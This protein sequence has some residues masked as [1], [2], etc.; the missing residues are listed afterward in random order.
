[1]GSETTAA[2]VGAVG[3]VRRD[4]MA[5]LPFCGYHMGDYFSHWFA[6]RKQIAEP[7]LIFGVNWFRKSAEG[8]FL[9]PGFGQNM[10]VL[11]WIVDRCHG[12]VPAKETSIGW[13]P[14]HGD[15][16]WRGM[17]DFGPAR[18]EEV[19]KVDPAEWRKELDSQQELF[20][21]LGDRMPKELLLERDRLEARL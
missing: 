2:A 1:M 5:M 4:P 9:W 20:A 11:K 16:N 14:E 17:E 7:P 12:R 13:T 10:R 6:M 21:K 3:L 15:F 18:F 8:K 19:Q